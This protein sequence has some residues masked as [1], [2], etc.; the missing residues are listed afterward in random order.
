M[1]QLS[2]IS[3]FCVKTS[4]F[5]C[6]CLIVPNIELWTSYSVLCSLFCGTKAKLLFFQRKSR[7]YVF[8]E[9]FIVIFCYIFATQYCSPF[10]KIGFQWIFKNPN[11]GG[12]Q[13]VGVNFINCFCALRPC[14]QL[15]RQYKASQKVGRRRRAKMDRAISMICAVRPTCMKLTP[16]LVKQLN[17]RH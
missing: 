13:M 1:V 11:M 3:N 14:T 8:L 4:F 2:Q 12:I 9:I 15:L 7:K 6:V 17:F 5:F 16:D 10:H